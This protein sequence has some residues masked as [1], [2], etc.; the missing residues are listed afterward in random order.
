V[1]HVRPRFRILATQ[2]W[3]THQIEAEEY[4]SYFGLAK[5][6]LVGTDTSAKLRGVATGY[7]MPHHEVAVK[8][9][10]A[11]TRGSRWASVARGYASRR[12]S[13]PRIR[14]H[15]AIAVCD[16]RRSSASG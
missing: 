3:R 10:R 15:Y 4:R 9:A 12:G 13:T 7:L 1:P 14:Q 2:V 11:A 16:L 5:R 8:L 6:G